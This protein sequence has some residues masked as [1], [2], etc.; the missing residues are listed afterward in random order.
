MLQGT[1][2][3]ERNTINQQLTLPSKLER[4]HRKFSLTLSDGQLTANPPDA[5]SCFSGASSTILSYRS[6][7][8]LCSRS[9]W[10]AWSSVCGVSRDFAVDQSRSTEDEVCRHS[11][12]CEDRSKIETEIE[13]PALA[14]RSLV[15]SLSEPTLAAS[16]SPHSKTPGS[17]ANGH[18]GYCG[19]AK[20]HAISWNLH[21][22]LEV[23]RRI[24]HTSIT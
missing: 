2:T 17:L 15:A 5:L 4:R 14:L 24:S 10:R 8:V 13:R 7:T 23:Y 9:A 21:P 19:H 18:D 1:W 16:S 22:L 3:R 6:A 12:Q 20:R 11:C